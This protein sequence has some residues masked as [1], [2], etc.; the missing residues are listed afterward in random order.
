VV[1]LPLAKDGV[2]LN[3]KD[4][5]YGQTLLSWAA[6]NRHEAVVKL[7]LAQDG[8]DRKSKSNGSWTPLSRA[9]VNG[10]QAVVELLL[11]ARSRRPGS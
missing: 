5:K 3:S 11:A 2:D 7:L 10:H 8:V 1:E 9:P 6:E 4:T